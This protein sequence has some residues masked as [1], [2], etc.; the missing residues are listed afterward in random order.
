MVTHCSTNRS[1]RCLFT[2]ER[3]GCEVFIVLWP[4]TFVWLGARYLTGL[5]RITEKRRIHLDGEFFFGVVGNCLD[6]SLGAF[7]RTT[8]RAP[9]GVIVIYGFPRESL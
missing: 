6:I 8:S 2:A 3:T 7:W 9:D 4:N 5:L 1:I